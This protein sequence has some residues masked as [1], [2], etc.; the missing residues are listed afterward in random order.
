M[1]SLSLKVRIGFVLDAPADASVAMSHENIGTQARLEAGRP[2]PRVAS[3]RRLTSRV[4]QHTDVVARSACA[5]VRSRGLRGRPQA[6]RATR[7]RA[8]RQRRDGARDGAPNDGARDGAPNDAG[9]AEARKARRRERERTRRR[10]R[11]G[12]GTAVHARASRDGR[13][14]GGTALHAR[15]GQRYLSYRCL[16]GGRSQKAERVGSGECI[17]TG[18]RNSQRVKRQRRLR[19]RQLRWRLRRQLRRQLLYRR[20]AVSACGA[21]PRALRSLPGRPRTVRCGH[22]SGV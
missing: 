15:R 17:G 16:H 6:R 3:S 12:G 20:R 11:Q 5:S 1:D 2:R 19:W 13:Q 4:A 10:G 9:A 18:R 22:S 14:G 8:A 21:R 7:E